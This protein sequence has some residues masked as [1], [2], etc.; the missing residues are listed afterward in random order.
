MNNMLL[1]FACTL[2]LSLSTMQGYAQPLQPTDLAS[3]EP[4]QKSGL[5]AKTVFVSKTGDRKKDSAAA[6]TAMH[7][8]MGQEGWTVIDVDIYIEDGDQWGFFVTYVKH[9]KE[10]L[11]TD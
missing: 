3:T 9:E 8:K 6:I 5:T 4:V 7:E 2:I 10:W 11:A 1:S